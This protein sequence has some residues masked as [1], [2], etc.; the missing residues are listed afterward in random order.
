MKR[1]S[2]GSISRKTVLLSVAVMALSV[3]S[4]HGAPAVTKKTTKKVTTKPAAKATTAT[5]APAAPA[6]TAAPT[7]IAA[8]I[9]NIVELAATDGSPLGTVTGS[10]QNATFTYAMSNAVNTLDPV[11]NTA[12]YSPGWYGQAYEGL[13]Q[14][15]LDGSYSGLLADTFAF[16]DNGLSLV[17]KLRKGV[18]FSD[19]TPFDA[20]A[21]KANIERG[22]NLPASLTKAALLPI[23][24][25]E[26]LDPLTAKFKFARTNAAIVDIL[27]DKAGLM[28][29]PAAFSRADLG[30]KPVG[31]GPYRL[32]GYQVGVQATYERNP[33][34]W[35]KPG[36]VAKIVVKTYT[37]PAASLNALQTGD[38]DMA[39]I[40]GE[41]VDTAKRAKMTIKTVESPITEH[42][43]LNFSTKFSDIRVRKALSYATDRSSIAAFA[44]VGKPAWQYALPGSN[45]WDKSVDGMFEYSP[46]KA[47]QLLTEAG[48]GNGFEFSLAYSIRPYTA[49]LAQILQQMWQKAGFKV[50]LRPLDAVSTVDIC[51]T[52]KQCDALVGNQ[53]TRLDMAALA[54]STFI[55]G[56]R[57]NL[58]PNGLPEIEAAVAEA[59]STLDD[60]KRFVAMKKINNLLA[61]LTP[62]VPIRS[63]ST[64]V[65]TRSGVMPF[66][67][68]LYSNPQWNTVAIKK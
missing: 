20:A 44:G 5:K 13:I 66:S 46:F 24:S 2:V 19:G 23:A 10:D 42:A 61:T 62:Y 21:V 45:L 58:G 34:Y 49:D 57:T 28:V 6:S 41:D 31:T 56:A 51:I 29:S 18:K 27:S 67:W 30:I 15:N 52:K 4:V 40:G 50:T 65:A 14:S 38:V 22:K 59:N 60:A 1:H 33:D 17:F 64:L 39:V 32:V 37:D 7:T 12:T 11:I 9:N 25:V 36:N 48:F 53:T 43:L 68:T 47:K 26:V 8:S 16:E 3:V 54:S 35:G 63:V 55:T